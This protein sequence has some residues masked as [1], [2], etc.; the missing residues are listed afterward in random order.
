MPGAEC[1]GLLPLNYLP[2]SLR[3]SGLGPDRLSGEGLR[4][5]SIYQR[6]QNAARVDSFPEHTLSM[7]FC[8][9]L[10]YFYFF[11]PKQLHLFLS[12]RRS[13]AQKVVG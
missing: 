7:T 8:S 13:L 11:K 2:A 6:G 9:I 4:L 3:K 10:F 5:V 12:I 1:P